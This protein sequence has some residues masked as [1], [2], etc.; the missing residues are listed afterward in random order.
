MIKYIALTTGVG[1]CLM[2]TSAVALK[3]ILGV[4]NGIS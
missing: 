1:F 4:V 3:M 2:F